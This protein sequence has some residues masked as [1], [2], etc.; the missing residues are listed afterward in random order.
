MLSYADFNT[1][2]GHIP[3]LGAYNLL[4]IT[5]FSTSD[6]L[7]TSPAVRDKWRYIMWSE[8]ETFVHRMHLHNYYRIYILQAFH[9]HICTYLRFS[10]TISMNN[11][12]KYLCLIFTYYFAFFKYDNQLLALFVETYLTFNRCCHNCRVSFI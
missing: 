11:F 9:R 8:N 12:H 3:A 2:F 6:R 10:K 4:R 5:N 1:V 7:L